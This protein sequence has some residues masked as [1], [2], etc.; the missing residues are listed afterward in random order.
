MATQGHGQQPAAHLS[1][2]MPV[3][4]LEIVA[5]SFMT[6]VRSGTHGHPRPRAAA[7]SAPLSL[8]ACVPCQ[9]R[10]WFVYDL[11][12]EWHTWPPKA[13]GSSLKRTRYCP[14]LCPLLETLYTEQPLPCLCQERLKWP[15]K[16]TGSSLERTS[17]S[18]C[19]CSLLKSLLLRS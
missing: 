9:S 4:P 15:P 10:C 2:F 19:L 5:G 8:H 16:A 13:K 1:L 17:L 3:S 7:W 11:C 12:Q 14:C 6:Y 18:S